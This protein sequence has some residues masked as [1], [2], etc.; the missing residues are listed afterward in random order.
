M[1]PQRVFMSALGSVG[2]NKLRSLLTLLGIVIGVAAVISLMSIGRGVQ[3]SV[4]SFIEDLGTNILFVSGNSNTLTLDDAYALLD[5]VMAP[6][7]EAVAPEVNAFDSVTLNDGYV[8][9]STSSQIVGVT[10]EYMPVREYEV[11]YGDFISVAHVANASDVAVL[12]SSVAEELFGVRNPVG[13]TVRLGGRLTLVI[14]V[15]KSRGGSAFGFEDQRVLVP[16]TTAYRRLQV[17]RSIRGEVVVDT[18]SVRV[19]DVK[20][21]ESAQDEISRVLRLRHRITGED[22]FEVGNQQD[23][24]E[25]FQDTTQAFVLFL[26]SIASISL[27]VGGIGIMNIMLVSVTE[28]TRE[29]GIRKAV[30]AKRRD[31]VLQFLTEATLLS[32]SGGMIGVLLGMG[33]A[34]L[35]NVTLFAEEEIRTVVSTDVT[36]LALGVSVMIGLVFGIYPAMRAAAFHPIEALRYE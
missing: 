36:A 19:A 10:P 35:M 12:G 24:L 29:I 14:G 9:N 34:R 20:D 22:D 28:R 18:I 15:L 5:P 27:L 21:I 6:S 31:I 3:E 33:I 16:I 4:T 8:V 23:A 13:Q 32:L 2:A 26:G 30:G 25:A 7:V 17:Q 11:E 1:S